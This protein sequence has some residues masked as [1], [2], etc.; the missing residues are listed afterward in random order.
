MKTE[1]LSVNSKRRTIHNRG[2]RFITIRTHHASLARLAL[3]LVSTSS[4]LNTISPRGT[5]SLTANW[6]ARKY[7]IARRFLVLCSCERPR[8]T[9]RCCLLT[10]TRVRWWILESL[11]GRQN[12]KTNALTR[13]CRS[14]DASRW[15]FEKSS[16]P[17]DTVLFAGAR[18]DVFCSGIYSPLPLN[19]YFYYCASFALY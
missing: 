1:Q 17:V 10:R 16:F 9:H 13:V 15:R 7:H 8:A 18:V 2:K 3:L 5:Y 4:V 11:E 14:D 19:S 12:K 6:S